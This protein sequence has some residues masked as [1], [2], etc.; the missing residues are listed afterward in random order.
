[1][2]WLPWQ[3]VALC[4][5]PPGAWPGCALFG[6]LSAFW[7]LLG[8]LLVGFLTRAARPEMARLGLLKED[9]GV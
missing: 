1:M 9:A 4:C 8:V 5:S 6:A 3:S 7:G 2:P